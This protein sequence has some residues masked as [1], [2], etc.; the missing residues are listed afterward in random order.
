MKNDL[1]VARQLSDSLSTIPGQTGICFLRRGENQGT[2][3]KNLSRQRREKNKK[4][5]PQNDVRST[6]GFKSRQHWWEVS[7]LAN[8]P[9]LLP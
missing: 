2:W 8:V 3:R 4:L 7:T 5:N 9:P 6:P 1:K